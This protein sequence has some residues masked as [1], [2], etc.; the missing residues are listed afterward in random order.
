MTRASDPPITR[1]LPPLTKMDRIK[2]NAPTYSARYDNIET[3][4]S[5]ED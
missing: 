4:I 5:I 1:G 3:F 2:K